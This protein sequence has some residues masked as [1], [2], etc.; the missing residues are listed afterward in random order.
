[1][2]DPEYLVVIR[3]KGVKIGDW[4]LKGY[5]SKKIKKVAYYDLLDLPTWFKLV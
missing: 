1:V 4:W 2:L 5:P 3:G